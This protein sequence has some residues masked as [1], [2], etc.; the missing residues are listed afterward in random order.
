LSWWKYW[1]A[2]G[3]EI[4][5]PPTIETKSPSMEASSTGSTSDNEDTAKIPAEPTAEQK[6]YNDLRKELEDANTA[7]ENTIDTL[8]ATIKSLESEESDIIKKNEKNKDEHMES[9][10]NL[11][12]YSTTIE[13]LRNEIKQITKEKITAEEE[14]ELSERREK[15]RVETESQICI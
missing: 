2:S 1:K 14:R 13:S 3:T 10:S 9:K 12:E 15:K 5:S 4:A 8:T 11:E 7:S 6:G